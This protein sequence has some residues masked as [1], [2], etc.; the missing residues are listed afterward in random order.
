MDVPFGDGEG[1]SRGRHPDTGG[2]TQVVSLDLLRARGRCTLLRRE[3][4]GA[5]ITITENK[6]VF[7]PLPVGSES[8][9]RSWW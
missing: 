2:I 8:E 7:Q 6:Y 3:A 1:T 4:S 5:S 9:L